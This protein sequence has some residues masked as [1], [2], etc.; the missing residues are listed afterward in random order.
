HTRSKRDWSSDVCSSDLGL[1]NSI[2]QGRDIKD[3]LI[4]AGIGLMFLALGIL[5][6]GALG[7]GDGFLL[8]ALGLASDTGEYLGTLLGGIFLRS[9]ERRVGNE[10]RCG[11]R[12]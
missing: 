12:G 10:G 6:G 7:A 9:E 3:F 8:L 2:I 5:S 1:L 4:P 11:W